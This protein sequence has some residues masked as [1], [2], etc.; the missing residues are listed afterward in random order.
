MKKMRIV[1]KYEEKIDQLYQNCRNAIEKHTES[2]PGEIQRFVTLGTNHKLNFIT[3]CEPKQKA[4][5]HQ[6]D[7]MSS[8]DKESGAY[9]TAKDL[10][11]SAENSILD[12]AEVVIAAIKKDFADIIES[13]TTKMHNASNQATRASSN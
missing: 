3:K 1:K 7:R 4:F 12:H 10:K 6:H 11:D 2:E 8:L 5:F 13:I 9:I